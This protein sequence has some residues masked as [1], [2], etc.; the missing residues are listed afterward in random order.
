MAGQLGQV[1]VNLVD[2][3]MVGRLGPASLASVSFGLAIFS[4]F[5]VFAM[6]ISFAIT[7]LVSEAD[8]AGDKPEISRIIK[9]GLLVNGV[10]AI[11]CIAVILT[12]LPVLHHLGQDPLV[13]ELASGYLYYVAMSLLPFML[14][15]AL[16]CFSDGMSE[17][18]PAMLI[19]ITGNVLN[20]ILNYGLIFG[21]YGMPEMGVAGAALASLIART[22]MLVAMFVILYYWKDLWS[23]LSACNWR[24]YQRKIFNKIANMGIPTSLQMFFEVSA[25]AG[26]SVIMGTISAEAQAAH[27]IAINLASIT[28]MTC[29]GLA[30]AST[31]RVGNQLGKKNYH[32]LRDAGV[33]ALIQTVGMMIVTAV[34]FSL[35]RHQLPYLYLDDPTTVGIASLLLLMAAIFQ[36]PDGIQVTAL[37]A[38]RGLQDLRIPTIITFVCYWMVAIP[39]SYAGAHYWGWGPVGVWIGLI[40]G[41]TLSAILM[42]RR[43]MRLSSDLLD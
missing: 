28:F 24:M 35:F 40:V 41:L 2:N 8:G 19:I 5:Y 21:N 31:I 11:I 14:F 36:V 25:F 16:K 43:F 15:Q 13:A 12:G 27:Q 37:S 20:V 29:L 17:T 39:M 6:G 32:K 3:L 22:F 34:F 18:M 4:S 10:F 7:P 42:T 23:Y 38:L 30:I 33:S 26:A 1:L 9:H